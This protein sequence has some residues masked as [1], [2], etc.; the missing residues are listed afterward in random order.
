MPGHQAVVVNFGEAPLLDPPGALGVSNIEF[1]GNSNSTINTTIINTRFI[2]VTEDQR[3]ETEFWMGGLVTVKQIAF[4]PF[5]GFA[6]IPHDFQKQGGSH[7]QMG[8]EDWPALLY[9][10]GDVDRLNS[11]YEHIGGFICLGDWDSEGSPHIIYDED[12]LA[13]MPGWLVE[14]WTEGVSGTMHILSWRELA[15]GE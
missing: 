15:G 3:F 14:D 13:N 10:T 6:L 9:G 1:D 5:Y 12:F 11:N 4:E 2:G 7:V 8:T